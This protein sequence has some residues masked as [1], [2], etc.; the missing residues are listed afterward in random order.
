MWGSRV[1]VPTKLREKV[2]KTLH[3]GQIGM[4]GQDEGFLPG[5]RLAAKH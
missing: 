1:V 4:H 5:V 2:L 3:E